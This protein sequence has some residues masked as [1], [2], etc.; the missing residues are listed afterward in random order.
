MSSYNESY[1]YYYFHVNQHAARY[2]NRKFL[3]FFLKKTYMTIN[4]VYN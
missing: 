2:K 3:K 1:Y 4:P